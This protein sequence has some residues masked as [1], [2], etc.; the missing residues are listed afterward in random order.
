MSRQGCKWSCQHCTYENWPKALRCTICQKPRPTL[1]EE[2]ASSEERDIYKVPLDVLHL[3]LTESWLTSFALAQISPLVQE[4]PPNPYHKWA[5]SKCTYLNWPQSIKCTQCLNPRGPSQGNWNSPGVPSSPPAPSPQATTS[6]ETAHSSG[7]SRSK[8]TCHACTYENWPKSR[9]CVMCSA[10]RLKA[11]SPVGGRTPESEDQWHYSSGIPSICTGGSYRRPAPQYGAAADIEASGLCRGMPSKR[12]LKVKSESLRRQVRE[13][14]R[15]WLNACRAVVDGEPEPISRYLSSGGDPGRQLTHGEAGLL[16][17]TASFDPGFTLAH[18][19]IRHERDDILAL[20]LSNP[21]M[22]HPVAKRVPS[23]VGRDTAADIRRHITASFKQKKGPFSSLLTGHGRCFVVA[24]IKE[25]HPSVQKVLFDEL[26]DQDVQKELEEDSA[27]INWSLELTETLGSRLYAL[28]NRSAGNCLL[29]SAL[30][31]TWGVFD[32]DNSLRQVLGDSLSEAAAVLYPRWR[33]AEALQAKLLHFTLDEAQWQEDWATLVSL[34]AQPGS[35]L[36]QMHVFT[37]AHVLRRPIVVYGVKYV[38]SFRGEAL[39]YARF[40]GG[41]QSLFPANGLCVA[42]LPLQYR[43]L[44]FVLIKFKEGAILILFYYGVVMKS[45]NYLMVVAISCSYEREHSRRRNV[46]QSKMLQ[47]GRE[48]EI[49]RQ[50][51]DCCVTKGGLL[52]AQQKVPRRPHL[53]LQMV[54]QW[55]DAYRKLSPH[56]RLTDA[57][58][59][60]SSDGDSDQE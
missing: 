42:Q 27:I 49:I 35:A 31:A 29:D 12:R 34:A 30:Q 14:D 58:G 1:I 3:C 13:A 48:E 5:C 17:R 38:K 15:L 46:T 40:E 45:G 36:E 10:A 28:W 18:M 8:W 52:V 20:L 44:V 57:Q 7:D 21:V 50:W 33:E 39:G 32:R 22:T 51:L 55:L 59:G 11:D 37:L 47:V 6:A 24:E 56:H 53:V 2:E 26:L 54:D 60:Y 23:D 4:P 43:S 19:A 41:H 25:F 16:A 9:K